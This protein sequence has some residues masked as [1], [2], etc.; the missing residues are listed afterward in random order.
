MSKDVAVVVGAG[1]MGQAIAR[2]QGVGTQLVPICSSTV[3]WPRR[4]EPV[5]WADRLSALT[6]TAVVPSAAHRNRDSLIC[7]QEK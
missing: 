1:G 2:R 7:C 4:S 5:G 6:R 3:A